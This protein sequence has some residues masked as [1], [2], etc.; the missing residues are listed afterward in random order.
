MQYIF[1]VRCASVLTNPCLL[2]FFLLSEKEYVFA[3]YGDL[4]YVW[5]AT[6]GTAGVSITAM[7]YEKVDLSNCYSGTWE[8]MPVDD[9]AVAEE[10]SNS[11][12][13]EAANATLSDVSSSNSTA[14]DTNAN[15]NGEII[16]SRK[17]TS[18]MPGYW[19][20]YQPKPSILSLLLQGKRLTAIV[21]ESSYM[22]MEKETSEPRVMSDSSKLIVRVYDISNIPTD[23]SALTLL[24]ER[25]LN[26]TSYNSARSVNDTAIIFATSYFDTYQLSSDLYPYNRQYCGLN[27]TEYEAPAVKT[28]LNKTER[29][30]ER[31][32][33]ELQVQ[34]DGKCDSI[35]QV[36]TDEFHA[37][38]ILLVPNN[39]IVDLPPLIPKVAAM[40]SGNTTDAFGGNLLGSFVQV[41]SFDA[42]S[43]FVDKKISTNIA[44]GFSSG[45]ISSIYATQDFAATLSVG[46]TYNAT[47]NYWDQ[48]T[49]IL[50]FDISTPIPKPF[51]Y[52]EIPGSPLNQYSADLY[53]GHLRVVTTEWFWSDATSTSTTT[54]KIFVLKVPKSGE[55]ST[56]TLTGETDHVGKPNESI[57]SV[58]FM[59][60]K[61]YVVTYLRKDPFYVYDLSNPSKPKKMG[62]LEIPGYSS[63]LHPIEIDGV[64]LMLG[65]GMNVNETT[66]W[67]TGVK[68]SLFDVTDPTTLRVNA[69]YVDEGAYSS[70]G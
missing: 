43:D 38:F 59:G 4:L 30:A 37:T 28:A 58:R 26:G 20:C 11:T 64:P 10:A 34:V 66:G 62:E 40:Q 23:G 45:W 12:S 33:E 55:G 53:E 31:M 17:A 49:F 67:E 48:A 65:I 69:T 27:D 51:S 41:I 5:N 68:I 22:P 32:L 47:T 15:E 14:S 7:P 63:Y 1:E 57:M 52:A 42:S 39:F 46:S 19:P 21:S 9:V 44:G 54:N 50:G 3:A 61:G 29:F 56:M 25:V 6:D 35:F 24:G 70:A 13:S 2:I 16:R 18:I 60:D 36:S 8:P